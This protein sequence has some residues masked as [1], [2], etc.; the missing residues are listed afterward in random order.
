[1]QQ[2]VK[3]E[4]AGTSKITKNHKNKQTHTKN[5]PTG[6]LNSVPQKTYKQYETFGS[7]GN[8]QN[9]AETQARTSFSRIRLLT[10][11][12]SKWIQTVPIK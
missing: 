8:L 3:M 7:P 12:F 1:M 10:K 11:K 2:I 9:P 5:V 6:H 4:P